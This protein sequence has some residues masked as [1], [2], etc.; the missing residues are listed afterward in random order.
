MKTAIWLGAFLS[1]GVGETMAMCTLTRFV[2]LEFDLKEGTSEGMTLE[3]EATPQ[4]EQD[5][6]TASQDF[7]SGV[8]KDVYGCNFEGVSVSGKLQSQ[9]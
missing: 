3:D 2:E 1:L 6:A 4:Q 7:F 5:L 9:S 8:F